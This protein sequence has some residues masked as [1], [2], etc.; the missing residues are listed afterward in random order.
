M[1]STIAAL[2]A[3]SI[4][5]LSCNSS[6][7][8][9]SLKTEKGYTYNLKVYYPENGNSV[10][11]A[12]VYDNTTNELLSVTRVD[13]R[14][15]FFVSYGTELRVVEPKYGI[16]QAIIKIPNKDRIVATTQSETLLGWTVRGDPH[17]GVP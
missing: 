1:K 16:Q 13:G 9:N 10:E 12:R 14:A 11:G 15:E 2:F 6:N 17:I 8:G 3:F 5:L 4:L 7:L